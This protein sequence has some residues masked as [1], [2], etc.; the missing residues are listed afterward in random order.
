MWKCVCNELFKNVLLQYDVDMK[1]VNCKLLT[2]TIWRNISKN[3][4]IQWW[5]NDT[6]NIYNIY[7]YIYNIYII[8]I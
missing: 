3:M 4:C 6:Y 2:K 8:Y 7:I 1:E 5:F